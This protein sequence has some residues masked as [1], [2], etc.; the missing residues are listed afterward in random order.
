MKSV[1]DKKVKD[2]ER[3]VKSA[4]IGLKKSLFLGRYTIA[5]LP[6]MRNGRMGKDSSQ[7]YLSISNKSSSS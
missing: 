3:V 7:N 6:T 2:K 5:S 4:E 1:R